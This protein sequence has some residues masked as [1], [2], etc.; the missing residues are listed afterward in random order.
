M[1]N[2]QNLSYIRNNMKNKNFLLA[3][4][5]LCFGFIILCFCHLENNKNSGQYYRQGVFFYNQGKYQDAYY[6]FKQIKRFSKLYEVSLLK[7]FQCAQKLEDKKT[8]Q[9]KLRDLIRATKNENIL[10]YALYQESILS[11]ENNQNPNQLV[12]K[13]KYI[14]KKFPTSDFG[15]ASGYKLANLIETK[16]P[17]NAYKQYIE[18]LKYAPLGK[19]SLKAAS[20]L[21][22]YDKF[23]LLEDYETIANSYFQNQKYQEALKYYQKAKFS[24]NWDNIAKCY[25]KLNNKDLEKTT[26]LKGLNLEASQVDEK[27]ISSQIDRLVLITKSNKLQTLQDLYTKYPNSY[28]TPTVMFK[29]AQQSSSVRAIKLYEALSNDYPNSIWASNS[30]W[31]VFWKNYSLK[32]Y[33]TCE[34]LAKKHINLYA[35]AQDAPRVLYWYGKV[36]LHERKN[37][38]AKNTFYKVINNYP[39]DFY[40]FLSARQLKISKAKKF[41]IKK[42]IVSYDINSLNK[43]LFKDK[44]LLF[45]A[46]NND[47]ETIE[48][49]KIND[50]YIKSLCLYK[51]EQYTQ[52]INV[53]KVAFEKEKEE[54]IEKN[55]KPDFSAHELKLIYP[56]LFENMINSNAKALKRSPYLFLSLIREES[57]FNKNAKS[58]AGAIGLSQLLKTTAEF[59]E[60]KPI[61]AQTLLNEEE[62]IK[63]GIKYFNYLYEIYNSEYLAILAYNAGPGNVN[64][65]LKDTDNPEIDAFIENIPFLETKNYIK[66][67]LRSYWIYINIYSS[68]HN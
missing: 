68:K 39:L 12:K 55:E 54:N 23:S 64:K 1:Y 19:F 46:K 18:Y 42:P 58:Q 49:L 24:A 48:D 35:H 7:Q 61:S 17:K 36:L 6:N 41:I 65:W 9:A 59:V 15:I 45:L 32:R 21:S 40:S 2:N 66:K 47:F 56:V 60:K 28:I 50:E 22:N 51:K 10:P 8:A 34:T 62:N 38:E 57:H 5:L 44:L 63:I 25:Q 37:Q 29:L 31:E 30:L 43:I 27:S 13:F 14:H 16:D 3:I 4:L 67:I 26:I 33:K 20:A 53:A 11:E 52:A